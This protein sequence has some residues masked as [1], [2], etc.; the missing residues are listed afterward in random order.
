MAKS[1]RFSIYLLKENFDA[2]NAL[3]D[4]NE[5]EPYTNATNLPPPRMLHFFCVRT[6]WYH[7]GGKI[8]LGL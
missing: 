7:L 6:N 3:T 4:G 1:R 5:L 2:S 8:I